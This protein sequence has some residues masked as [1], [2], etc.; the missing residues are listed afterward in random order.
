MSKLHP[1]PIVRSLEYRFPPILETPADRVVEQILR[2]I[3]VPQEVLSEAKRR[4]DLVLRIARGHEASN[5]TYVSG[6]IAHGTQNSPLGDA[7]SGVVIDRRPHIFR[8]FGPDAGPGARGPEVF[9]QSFASF[10]EPRVRDAGYP[11]LTLDLTGNRAI[12]FEFNE[13]IEFEDGEP[14]DPYVDLI[15]A[16]RRDEDDKGLWIPDRRSG[17]WDPANPERHTWLM[18][19]RDDRALSVHRA[20]VVRLAKRAVKRDGARNPLGPVMCSWNLS[21]LSLELVTSRRPLA[22]AL[23]AFFTDASTA[24][25]ASVTDDPAGVA[26]P[27]KLPRGITQ[28]LA[29][30]RL[31]DFAEIAWAAVTSRSPA[32]ASAALANLF[33]AELDDIRVREQ[34]ALQAHPL[35]HSLQQRDIAGATT[36]LGSQVPLK[37]TASDGDHR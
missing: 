22:T 20:H 4:R 37:P 33:A 11:A 19:R 5:R 6:S 2:Q 8:A 1:A 7:D 30:R 32:G 21:A 14:V 3:A 18:T 36:A 9:Y 13:P 31:A 29:A 25:A 35:N 28:E 34:R 24:I 23:A 10:I 16:L 12:K 15:V 27:I 26:G 17:W